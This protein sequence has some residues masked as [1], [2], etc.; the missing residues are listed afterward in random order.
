MSGEVRQREGCNR[1]LRKGLCLFKNGQSSRSTIRPGVS[2]KQHF[3][4]SQEL[5]SVWLRRSR[6]E[7]WVCST[8]RVQAGGDARPPVL[9]SHSSQHSVTP[10]HTCIGPAKASNPAAQSPTQALGPD[11]AKQLSTT[12]AQRQF[13]LQEPSPEVSVAWLY[14]NPMGCHQRCTKE[15]FSAAHQHA[16]GRKA[17]FQAWSHMEE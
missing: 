3:C 10:V 4:P 12:A 7:R 6:R 2:L 11:A 5:G 14:P 1:A 9:H 16:V 15:A 8:H 13:V 17:S